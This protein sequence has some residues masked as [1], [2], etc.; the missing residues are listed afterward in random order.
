MRYFGYFTHHDCKQRGLDFLRF[1]TT[2]QIQING[3]DK[4]VIRKIY[5]TRYT[6]Y[7][8]QFQPDEPQ[9]PFAMIVKSLFQ[10]G[11]VHLQ[12]N[13]LFSGEA[14][15]EFINS[16]HSPRRQ[17]TNRTQGS[18]KS[19]SPGQGYDSRGMQPSPHRKARNQPSQGK[20]AKAS[21]PSSDEKTPERKSGNRI[22][23]RKNMTYRVAVDQHLMINRDSSDSDSTESYSSAKSNQSTSFRVSDFH[24]YTRKV[25]NIYECVACLSKCTSR[26]EI[27]RHLQGKRHRLGVMTFELRKRR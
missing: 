24:V 25:G 13:K 1:L 18:N 16:H 5:D 3:Q 21:S 11:R 7:R 26:D 20:N 12:E 15:P 14:P 10:L 6:T 22:F 8:T 19:R 23:K 2:E 17:A 27:D 4:N 9:V